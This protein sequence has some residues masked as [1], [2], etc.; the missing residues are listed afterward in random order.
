MNSII[1]QHLGRWATAI[2][3]KHNQWKSR[4]EL[5]E[6]QEQKLRKLL[7][8]AKAN[9]PHYRKKFEGITVRD[10]EALQQLPILVRSDVQNSGDALLS[11]KFD[12]SKL[13]PHPT[14]G[15]S[16]FPICPYYSLLE[17]HYGNALSLHQQ[18]EAGFGPFDRLA[19]LRYVCIPERY[20]PRFLYKVKTLPLYMNETEALQ[21]IKALKA[22]VLRSYAS[23]LTLLAAANLEVG[24]SFKKL[25]SA[26]EYLSPKARKLIEKSF[27]AKVHDFY[28]ANEVSWVAWECEEGNMHIHSDSVILEIVDEFGQPAKEGALLITSLWRYSMPFIRYRIGDTA[29]FGTS[30]KCGRGTHILKSLKGQD[31]DFFVLKSGRPWS[32][33]FLESVLYTKK[34][35]VLYQAHQEAPGELTLKIVSSGQLDCDGTKKE[36]QECLPEPTKI[37]IELVET[38]PKGRTGKIQSFISKLKSTGL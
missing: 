7:E 36:L 20:T 30:C 34:E 4:A 19:Y 12:K 24:L 9:V 25:F 14:T 27:S 33:M 37:D 32:P 21:K 35:I 10:V 6:L 3:M 11:R 1:S 29:S 17:G 22:N 5:E 38:L 8:Y 31:N 28:G 2:Q 18:T 15:S 16:G 26:S 23:I 13:L